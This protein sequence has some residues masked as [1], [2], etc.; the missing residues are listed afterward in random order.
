MHQTSLLVV[1]NEPCLE[2]PSVLKKTCNK[3]N[4]VEENRGLRKEETEEE[5]R[6]SPPG[7]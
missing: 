1:K 2:F 6:D 4:K 5:G 7:I 3:K